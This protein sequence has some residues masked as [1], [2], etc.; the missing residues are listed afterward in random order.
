M[1]RFAIR[2]RIILVY[3]ESHESFSLRIVCKNGIL[4]VNETFLGI[5]SRAPALQNLFLLEGTFMK[6]AVIIVRTLMG[7]F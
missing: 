4:H 2:L 6:I 3:K 5:E 7:Q 1:K